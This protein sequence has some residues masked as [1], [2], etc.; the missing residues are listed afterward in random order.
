LSHYQQLEFVRQ[1]S[2]VFPEHFNGKKVLEVGSWD[3]NGSVRRFFTN[4]D[5]LGADVAAGPGVDLVCEGQELQNSSGYFDLV[6]S[7]ECFEHNPYWL[8][9][10]I[11]MLRMLKPGGVCVVTCATT[12][13]G[14]HGT[15]RKLEGA[16]LS[17]QDVSPDYY[18]NLTPGDFAK[19]LHLERHFSSYFFQQN[20]YSKDLYFVG[21]KKLTKHDRFDGERLLS[22]K[23]TVGKITVEDGRPSVIKRVNSQ[24]AWFFKCLTVKLLGEE[25]YH[26]FKHRYKSVS[27]SLRGKK[28][29]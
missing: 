9:T 13:R 28:F 22:L 29:E 10:F 23:E 21:V 4:C 7:C 17:S 15:K 2:Q 5:Y 27:R 3:T 26:D 6:I 12:G 25:N 20:I 11:N 8:E 14:E 1:V 16:S 24:L 19:R 18:H